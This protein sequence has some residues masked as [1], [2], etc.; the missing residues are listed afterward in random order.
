MDRGVGQRDDALDVVDVVVLLL[1]Y[2]GLAVPLVGGVVPRQD[3]GA[4]EVDPVARLLGR[5]ARGEALGDGLRGRD[6]VRRV[7]RV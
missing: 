2:G 5:V 7:G 4:A 6:V 3:P 1:G